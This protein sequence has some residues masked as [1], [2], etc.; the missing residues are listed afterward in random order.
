MSEKKMLNGYSIKPNIL[1]FGE[2]DKSL[3]SIVDPKNLRNN[4]FLEEDSFE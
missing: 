1:K 2:E 3:Q 4:D